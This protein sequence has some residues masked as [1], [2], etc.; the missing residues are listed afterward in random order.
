MVHYNNMEQVS[1]KVF[2]YQLGTYVKK[3]IS[4][5]VDYVFVGHETDTS[6]CLVVTTPTNI[7]KLSNSQ[8]F[9]DKLDEMFAA[10]EKKVRAKYVRMGQARHGIKK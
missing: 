4:G 5:A 7:K 2:R 6:K 1:S 8:E 9:N 10:H 3:L